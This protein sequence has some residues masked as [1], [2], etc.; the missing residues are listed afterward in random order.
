MF[1]CA[2]KPRLCP[3]R[4]MKLY[5]PHFHINST[6]FEFNR[7]LNSWRPILG[8]SVTKEDF[9]HLLQGPGVC[10]AFNPGLFSQSFSLH[11]PSHPIFL[12]HNNPNIYGIISRVF[13]LYIR[14]NNADLEF[15]LWKA[16]IGC[17]EENKKK[18]CE[19]V[20]LFLSHLLVAYQPTLTGMF[21]PFNGSSKEVV[22][23]SWL[24]QKTLGM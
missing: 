17:K 20:F 5:N 4:V 14:A 13:S 24:L 8:D 12:S 7:K 15:Y 22:G 23:W 21:C 9:K 10:P 6:H 11:G 16:K 19:V 3:F 18:N 2:G 1:L